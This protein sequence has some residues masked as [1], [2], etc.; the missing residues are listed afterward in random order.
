VSEE[1]GISDLRTNLAHWDAVSDEYQQEHASQ[2]NAKPLAWGVF[3]LSEDELRVLGEVKG[4]AVLELGC[5]AAQWS[6]FLVGR[7][8]RPIG[9]DLSAKQLSHAR[10]L[11]GEF[12]ASVPVV[13]GSAT[14]LSFSP[15]AFDVVFCDHGAMSFADPD[16]T[17]P[18][19]ARVLR[20]GGLFAFSMTTPLVEV[21]VDP[22][23]DEVDERLHVDYFGLHRIEGKGWGR[24]P[25]VMFQLPYGTWI[26]LFRQHGLIVEDL[27][28][29]RATDGTTSTY[30]NQ[31]D[32]EWSKRWPS[33]HIWKLRKERA[34]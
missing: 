20:P 10:R 11:M 4:K 25:H 16:H 9:L 3:A 1:A 30:W 34:A 17:V 26:R 28:E 8:A 19:V 5:G 2:L 7:G 15:E 18:E 32:I 27:I 6:I 24:G 29:T 22:E 12:G 31:R 14:A 21:C 33:E 23:T 13:Q